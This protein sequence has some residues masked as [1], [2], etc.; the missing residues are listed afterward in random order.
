MFSVK[1]FISIYGIIFK[2]ECP[3]EEGGKEE[4]QGKEE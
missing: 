3:V 4:K 2:G 1:Q